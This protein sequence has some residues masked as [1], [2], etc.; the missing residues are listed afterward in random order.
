MNNAS[1]LLRISLTE[2]RQLLLADQAFADLMSARVLT[3][4]SMALWTPDL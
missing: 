2:R 3:L 1:L 4:S